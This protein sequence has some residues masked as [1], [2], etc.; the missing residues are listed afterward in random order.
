[1]TRATISKAFV[2]GAA[3]AMLAATL[4]A[5]GGGSDSG[6][7]SESGGNDDGGGSAQTVGNI[8]GVSASCEAT[9]N[10]VAVTGQIVAGQ[11]PADQ[12]RATIERFV[13]E[14][15]SEIK[16]DAEIFATTYLKWVEVLAKFGSD[17]TKAY[18][19]PEAAAVLDDLNNA[20]ASG[21]FDRISEYVSKEC[22]G[23]G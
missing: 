8:A 19:D 4:F 1:M 3:A 11:I 12:A 21:A 18:E 2:R 16:A 6:A 17:I 7:D 14:A 13:K 5:C 10:L 15:P 20:E 22:D 23:L 9:I